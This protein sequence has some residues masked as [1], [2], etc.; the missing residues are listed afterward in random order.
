MRRGLHDS[1]HTAY[2]LLRT[3]KQRAAREALQAAEAEAEEGTA[4]V[5]AKAVGTESKVGAEAGVE[6]EEAAEA[7]TEAEAKAAAARAKA[8][9]ARAKVEAA[10]A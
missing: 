1:L 2:K 3:K 10:A 7:V 9:E 8:V 4:P 5:A 6:V